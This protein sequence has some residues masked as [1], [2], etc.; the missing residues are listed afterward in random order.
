MQAS[1]SS[2]TGSSVLNSGKSGQTRFPLHFDGQKLQID[3]YQR[4]KKKGWAS[5]VDKVRRVVLLSS[6]PRTFRHEP[7]SRDQGTGS[8]PFLLTLH[9]FP[10]LLAALRGDS[11]ESYRIRG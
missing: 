7:S 11:L 5:L 2:K 8:G 1:L 9:W 4:E 3:T 6:T 10:F